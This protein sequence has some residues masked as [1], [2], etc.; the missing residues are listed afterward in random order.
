M[1]RNDN[2]VAGK[3]QPKP[4]VGL[5]NER[6]PGEENP[7]PDGPSGPIRVRSILTQEF[8]VM[9]E[10]TKEILARLYPSKLDHRSGPL[11]S[12]SRNQ[13]SLWYWLPCE[14]DLWTRMRQ[15]EWRLMVHYWLAQSKTKRR[16]FMGPG[17]LLGQL[18]SPHDVL[19]MPA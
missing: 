12:W 5:E 4:P 17:G 1:I 14:L 8:D 15:I 9:N 7:F 13:A 6:C 3:G 19:R 10:P 2:W 16:N 18:P 11:M